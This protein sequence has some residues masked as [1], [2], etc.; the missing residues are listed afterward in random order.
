[1]IPAM[2]HAIAHWSAHAAWGTV[3]PPLVEVN[4]EQ[5]AALISELTQAGFS[6]PG[7]DKA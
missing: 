7:L 1:M 2:K 6:M 3:R 4:A 5:S